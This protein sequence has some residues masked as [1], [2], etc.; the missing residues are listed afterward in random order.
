MSQAVDPVLV[1]VDTQRKDRLELKLRQIPDRHRALVANR[2]DV[3]NEVGRLDL[4][5]RILELCE[6]SRDHLLTVELERDV[7]AVVTAAAL[8]DL[9]RMHPACAKDVHRG[10]LAALGCRDGS[11]D[12][13][14]FASESFAAG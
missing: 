3:G 2:R 7:G 5:P 8:D 9:D 1:H 14:R 6:R 12:R 4:I 11:F 13:N 10:V